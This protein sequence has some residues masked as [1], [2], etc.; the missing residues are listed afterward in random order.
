MVNE[1]EEKVYNPRPVYNR[2]LLRSVIRAKV[3]KQFGFHHVNK[4]MAVNFEK[5]RK[6]Q[7]K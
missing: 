4:M 3:A 7:V 6:G 2:K 5:I 1:R